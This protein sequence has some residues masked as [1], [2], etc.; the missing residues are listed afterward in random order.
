[1]LDILGPEGIE[2]LRQAIKNFILW[3]RRHVQLSEP[4]PS[5]Q[6]P[7]FTQDSSALVDPLPNPPSSPIVAPIDPPL[8]L[9][10]FN[11]PSSPPPKDPEQT[12]EAPER[13]KKKF[14]IPKLVSPFEPK[15]ITA[16]M[17]KFLLGIA[18]SRTTRTLD[19]AEHEK[20][21]KK[22]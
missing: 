22:G 9:P 2:K 7:P 5:S 15:K 18:L 11:S 17:V 20:L 10:P 13:P 3:P 4:P 1:M 16:G 21:A 12:Q 8:S 19:L 14:L 6:V